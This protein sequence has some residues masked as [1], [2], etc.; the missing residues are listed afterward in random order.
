MQP[1]GE[2]RPGANSLLALCVQAL[3]GDGR[4]AVS[5]EPPE[6]QDQE[7]ALWLAKLDAAA[8]EDVGLPLPAYSEDAALWGAQLLYQLCRF[9]VCRDIPEPE[10]KGVCEKPFPLPR[11]PEVDWSVDLT[12]RHL[13]RLFQMAR[14]LSNADP[15]IE[16]M[17]RLAIL[18]PLSSIGIAG[19]ERPCLGNFIEHATLV[20]L[21][22][23]RILATSDTSRLGEPQVDALLRADLGVH[24]D[25]AP[26]IAAKLFPPAHD[27]N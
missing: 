19:I 20:R 24:R 9:V 11:S 13:P 27:S 2:S 26:D 7:T 25:L 8:R 22:A 23:D 1:E 4:L 6:I 21:Y 10:I 12:L 14:H 17:K 15:L 3:L 5:A 18:W 16:Q